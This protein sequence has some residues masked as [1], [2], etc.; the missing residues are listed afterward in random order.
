MKN[1]KILIS[2]ANGL[3]GHDLI[4]ELSKNNTIFAI[5]RKQKS[6][7]KNV[8]YIELDLSS[9]WSTTI[10]PKNIDV[11]Y[12]LA[13]SQNFRDF[14]NQ[15]LDIFKV[16]TLST[17][18]LLDYAI[19]A[20]CQNFIYASTGGVY[21]NALTSISEET[22][23]ELSKNKGYYVSS[24]LA[25]EL[26]IENYKNHFDITIARFFFVYGERQ[27]QSML[28][29]RLVKN[30][31]EENEITIIGEQGLVIN[32]IHVNDVTKSLIEMENLKGFKVVN[33]G[34]TEELSL[35]Q[36]CDVIA[37][38]VNVKPNYNFQKG[39]SNN[40]IGNIL[41][42]KKELSVPNISFKEGIA[43]LI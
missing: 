7:I 34:G 33:I 39:N 19:K 13:Q 6:N 10:L 18:L 4:T 41:K 28:I 11:I 16:N 25:S 3:I 14:P 36:I 23:I 42:M 43:K 21:D 8:N 27:E 24:K 32:P 38:I 29:P 40:L 30:I 26:L 12:H 15:A 2:G 22:S 1:K 5:T 35:K 17:A 20:N 37:N 9:N 31:K